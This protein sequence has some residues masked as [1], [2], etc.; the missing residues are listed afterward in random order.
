M[1]RLLS[2][3][4][5]ADANNAGVGVDHA[6]MALAD[7]IPL[8][9][10]TI[11]KLLVVMGKPSVYSHYQVKDAKAFAALQAASAD[12]RI[13]ALATAALEQLNTRFPDTVASTAL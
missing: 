11:I 3:S 12:A 7:A 4:G 8:A 5:L 1:L 13:A 2:R 6:K 10:S 9:P